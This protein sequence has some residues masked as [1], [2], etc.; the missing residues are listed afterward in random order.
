EAYEGYVLLTAAFFV[1]TMIYWMQRTA[2]GIK[3]HIE[4]R[5]ESISAEEV[6]SGLGVFLFVFL[7]VFREGAETVLLSSAVSLNT[8]D[9][10]NFIGAAVGLALAVVFGV[11]FIRGTVRLDLRKFFQVTTVILVFVVLQLTITGFH[12]LSE[13]GVLPSSQREMAIVGPIVSNDIFFVVAIIALAALMVLF[14]WRSRQSLAVAGAPA[15]ESLSDAE[16]RQALYRARREKLWTAAVCG[17]S[18]V[19]I[20]LLTAEFIYAK[21]R[22]A[23]SPA[24]AVTADGGVI[25]IPVESVSDGNL[26]RFS[27]S[28]GDA[29]V[30]FIVVRTA[31]RL[32]TAIDACEICG[33]QGY[34][35]NGPE[36]FC[37]NC[38]A[39][40]YTPTIGVAG[41]C[42]PI[43]LPA[44]DSGTE[45]M[46]QVSDLMGQTR[47][48]PAGG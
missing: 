47:R 32:A 15:A 37:R 42:N 5:L 34:Y 29:S 6:S 35:Q 41:G 44:V 18:F 27:Y 30:R 24:Q 43:P 8:D 26:H 10:L 21:S 45:L 48:F 31:G 9:L 11:V 19:F 7:M 23:L 25:R 17:S 36:I 22:T 4:G 2:K 40:I 16:R 20:V 33:S 13:G 3:R 39:A 28:T 12:E 38:A 14:D 1:A 46:I